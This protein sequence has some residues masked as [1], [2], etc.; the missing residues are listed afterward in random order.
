MPKR[1]YCTSFQRLIISRKRNKCEKR[2]PLDGAISGRSFPWFAPFSRSR[3]A[4]E[5]C[6]ETGDTPWRVKQ[7]RR[8]DSCTEYSFYGNGPSK[9]LIHSLTKMRDGHFLRFR[10]FSAFGW[11]SNVFNITFKP[12]PI[13]IDLTIKPSDQDRCLF[14]NAFTIGA[15]AI[16]FA[17]SAR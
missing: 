7:L 2:H 8:L 9:L 15:F 4:D 17:S 12:L 6:E 1:R 14:L 11:T 3:L 10:L 16:G 5:T 13:T